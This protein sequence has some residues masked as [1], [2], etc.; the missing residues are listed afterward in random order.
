MT[1]GAAVTAPLFFC[2]HIVIPSTF[3]CEEPALT[4]MKKKMNAARKRKA[5]NP[6]DPDIT[7]QQAVTEAR[8]L[9][10]NAVPGIV[11]G[12][13]SKA[14]DGH[15]L[16]ARMLFDL[17]GFAVAAPAAQS[18]IAPIVE[19]LMREMSSAAPDSAPS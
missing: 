8:R 2:H 13:I 9:V 18:A 19:L 16:H 3:R 5:E 1:K 11:S 10:V 4:I 15:Y 7:E 12:V 17:I 14:K 6:P